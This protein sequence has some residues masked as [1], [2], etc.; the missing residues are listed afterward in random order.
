VKYVMIGINILPSLVIMAWLNK[1][2][3]YL[4]FVEKIYSLISFSFI[5]WIVYLGYVC[6]KKEK[7]ERNV[8]IGV[9]IGWIVT[10][11]L[12]KWVFHLFT[13]YLYSVMIGAMFISMGTMIVYIRKYIKK[14]A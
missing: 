10:Y 8:Q 1:I 14:N 12:M 11:L 5:C 13:P 2:E 3:K 7:E 6:I 9:M 4:F